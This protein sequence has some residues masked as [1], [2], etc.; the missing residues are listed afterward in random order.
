V[1]FKGADYQ[2]AFAL[3]DGRTLWV[4]QDVYIRTR[5]GSRFVHNAGLVQDGT[6]FTLLHTGTFAQPGAWLFADQTQ[7][8]QHWFWPLA[9]DIG[10]DGRFH[11]FVAE[12]RENTPTYL[13]QTEPTSTWVVTI[14][15]TTLQVTDRRKAVDAGAALYGWSVTSSD[16]YTYLYAHCHRQFGWSAFPFVSPPVY[17]HDLGCASRITVARVPRGQFDQPMSYWNGSSWSA[18]PGSAVNIVPG[19]RFVSAGQFFFRNG[20]WV[21]VTKLGDWFGDKLLV[22]V[23]SR[24]QGPYRTVQTIVPTERCSDC[25]TYAPTLLPYPDGNGNWIVGISNNSFTSLDLRV[26][27]PTFLAIPPVSI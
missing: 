26:Y 3:P 8:Q 6:C 2:R 18:D 9:G 13:G 11:L 5:T 20:A 19:D 12:M 4:F 15:P 21:S 23:A 24:P 17:I 27:D 22:E 25:N 10:V 16:Q 1:V 14:D 7:T